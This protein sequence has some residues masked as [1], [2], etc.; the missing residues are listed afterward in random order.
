MLRRIRQLIGTLVIN[1]E[2]ILILSIPQTGLRDTIK[3]PF[4]L[5][6]ILLRWSSSSLL[7]IVFLT[8]PLR[9]LKYILR[10]EYMD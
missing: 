7:F 8:D 2:A 10:N 1:T 9:A 3:P 6:M 4:R 5:S